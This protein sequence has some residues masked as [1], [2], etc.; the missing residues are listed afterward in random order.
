M[1]ITSDTVFKRRCLKDLK[2]TFSFHHIAITL[3]KV[4]VGFQNKFG[5]NVSA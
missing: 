1:T 2:G 4:Y 3:W 5:L